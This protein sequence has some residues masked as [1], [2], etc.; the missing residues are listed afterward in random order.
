MKSIYF[1]GLNGVRFFAALL[2]IIDHTELFKSYLGYQT[3]WSNGYSSYLGGFGVTIFF[4]LSGYLI[5]YL[6]LNEKSFSSINI[7]HFYIRRILR[8]WPVYFLVV[9]TTFFIIPKIDLFHVPHYYAGTAHYSVSLFLYTGM[10]AN[11]AA[12]FYPT[13]AFANVLWSVAVEEQFYLLWPHIIKLKRSLLKI[14]ISIIILY[15]II[16]FSLLI[17]NFKRLYY[18]LHISCFPALIIGGIGAYFVFNNSRWIQFL[19]KRSV[20]LITLI[21]FLVLLSNKFNFQ[22]YGFAMK[23]LN[24]LIICCLIINI[25]TNKNSIVNLENKAF[26]YLGKISYGMYAYHL[27]VVV[28]VLKLFPS[29]LNIENMAGFFNYSI[30]FVSVLLITVIISH[31]SYTYFEKWFLDKKEDFSMVRSIKS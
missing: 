6:L 25:S 19:Y 30:I 18:L 15:F 24:S 31:L 29:Y 12:V 3:V 28:V 5:T 2:V 16:K 4:V 21:L 10:L 26:N 9:F 8:I 22:Y 20:Q 11:V 13:V 17:F 14:F 27:P 7:K 1:P 23:E